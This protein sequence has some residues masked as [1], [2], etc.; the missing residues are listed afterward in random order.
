MATEPRQRPSRR[1]IL[2][3]VTLILTVSWAVYLNALENDFTNWDDPE[4]VVHNPSIRGLGW[5]RLSTILAPHEAGASGIQGVYRPVWTLSYALDYRLGALDPTTYHFHSILLHSIAAVLVYILATAVGLAGFPALMTALLFAVHPVHVE[6]VAWTSG[7]NEVLVT[8]FFL[9]AY[10]LACFRANLGNGFRAG[11]Y[12][13]SLACLALA[14]LS[15]ATAAVFALLAGVTYFWFLRAEAGVVKRRGR[16]ILRHLPYLLMGAGLV[17]VE[18]FVSRAVV[19]V[20]PE[21]AESRT[22]TL[23]TVPKVI[24][25]YLGALVLPRGLSPR[26]DTAYV[27]G[28]S[29]E[30]LLT[31]LGL[32]AVVIAAIWIARRLPV[33]GLG[34]WWF[35]LTLLPAS[36]IL[37]LSTLR[38]DRFLYLPSVGFC[39]AAGALLRTRGGPIPARSHFRNPVTFALLGLA[40]FWAFGTVR[41][42]RVW[43]NSRTLWE[44]AEAVAP[45]D[46]MVH[47]NLG[48]A[49]FEA[50]RPEEAILAFERSIALNPNFAKAHNNLGQLYARVGR[51][52]EGEGHLR[53]AIDLDPEY[54][55]AYA[56]LGVLYAEEGRLTDAIRSLE[57]AVRMNPEMAV[58]R[59]NLG[60]L[61]ASTGR[62][63]GAIREIQRALETDLGPSDRRR[64]EILLRA[65]SAEGRIEE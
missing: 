19:V 11:A 51:R 62:S 56:N 31:V 45:G 65:L 29:T 43:R 46:Y 60:Q 21:L 42:N 27:T 47:H 16:C 54:A 44:H 48:T 39:L 12:V 50:G 30:A 17:W 32:G 5:T 57:E 59:L 8:L 58:A 6:A 61:Y 53:Q 18:V 2:I 20:R 36:N 7:R 34:S 26:Y 41:Q 28:A 22:I 15:K 14:L 63:E 64:A 3:H 1:A 10:L 33:F 55:R 4:V 49:Y 40:L 24:L 37:L 23:L 52:A 9:A 38:A 35:A 25:V 13:L